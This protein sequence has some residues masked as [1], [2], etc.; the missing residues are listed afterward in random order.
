MAYAVGPAVGAPRRVRVE[1]A[2]VL[3]RHRQPQAVADDRRQPR[4]ARPDHPVGAQHVA[5]AERAR[6]ERPGRDGAD[7]AEGEDPIDVEPR[8]TALVVLPRHQLGQPRSV[9]RVHQHRQV[10][11]ALE[12]SHAVQIERV[13]GRGLEGPDASFAQNDVRVAF[14]ENVL[15]GKQQFLHCRRQAPL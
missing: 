5:L 15:G 11:M 4:P 9:G 12:P 6:P 14:V 8:R 10:G 7:P 3:L 13:A 1:P 2:Y